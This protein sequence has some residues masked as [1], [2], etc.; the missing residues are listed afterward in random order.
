MIVNGNFLLM[1][2]LVT[3]T[4]Y[5]LVGTV[6]SDCLLRIETSLDSGSPAELVPSL[7]HLKFII[8]ERIVQFA[9]KYKV[10]PIVIITC[11]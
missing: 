7:C 4:S 11:M 1:F 8:K 2:R 5:D 3:L 10:P 9:Q 6:S